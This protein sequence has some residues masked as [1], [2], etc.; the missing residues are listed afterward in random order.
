MASDY[1]RAAA[2]DTSKAGTRRRQRKVQVFMFGRGANTS[3]S[4]DDHMPAKCSEC[5][6][7]GDLSLMSSPQTQG[8]EYLTSDQ[9]PWS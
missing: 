1:A 7:A 6:V 8:H 2:G 5:I 4:M 9:G 3:T